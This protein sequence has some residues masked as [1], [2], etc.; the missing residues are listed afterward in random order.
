MFYNKNILENFKKFLR[1]LIFDNQII[2]FFC[3]SLLRV[4][5]IFHTVNFSV[6]NW[7][8]DNI[9]IQPYQKLKLS[10]QDITSQYW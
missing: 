10:K 6:K 3:R 8:L 5:K 9:M 1:T 4:V 7:K 2:K